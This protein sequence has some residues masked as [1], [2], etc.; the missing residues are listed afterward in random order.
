ML[1]SHASILAHNGDRIQRQTWT[2]EES[3][4]PERGQAAHTKRFT[5]LISV[6]PIAVTRAD[7]PRT[8]GI[9]GAG[10]PGTSCYRVLTHFHFVPPQRLAACP[11]THVALDVVEQLMY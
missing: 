3:F 4:T 10:L 7:E 5:Q 6:S 8:F 11:D 1:F 9:N 2:V